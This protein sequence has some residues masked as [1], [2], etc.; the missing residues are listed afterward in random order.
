MKKTDVDRT[1]EIINKMFLISGHDVTFED[2]KDRHDDWYNQ[3][4]MTLEQEEEWMNWMVQYLRKEKRCSK[5]FAK[6]SAAWVNLMFG[7]KTII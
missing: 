7:L 4:T 3:Y 5:E 6:R 2:V 1:K